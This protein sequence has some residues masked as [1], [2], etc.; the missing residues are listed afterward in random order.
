[1]TGYPS[2]DKPWLKYYSEEALEKELPQCTVYELLWQ[3]NK[4]YFD[5]IALSYLGTEISFKDLFANIEKTAK[6]FAALGVKEGDIVVMVT[7]TTPET[8]YALY[9]LNRLGAIPNM[10]D[11]RTSADGMKE[12]I[13]EVKAK[14]VLILDVVYDKAIQIIEDTSVE[15]VIVT[16]PANSLSIIKKKLYNLFHRTSNSALIAAD[17]F[18]QWDIFIEQGQTSK[19]NSVPYA[20]N[21][22]CLM[23]HT[24]GTTG[25]PKCVMLSNENVNALV[26][27]SIDTEI[28]MQ[29]NHTWLDIMPPFIAYGFGMGLHLPLVIGMKTFLIPQFDP[30]KF[31]E[32]LIKYKPVH[33][34]GVPS[35]W[36]TILKS[37]KLK[38]ADLSYMISPTVGGDSMAPNL[39]EAANQFLKSHGCTSKITKGYGM[40]EVCAGVAGTVDKNNEIGSV[41]IPFSKTI[42]SIF[43]P[44]TESELSYNQMG[45]VCITGPNVMLGYYNN[46]EATKDIIKVH[47]DGKSWIH[48]GDIGYM[49][50]NGSLFIVDRIKKMIVRY[51]GFKVYPAV[52]D[53]AVMKHNAV[54]E[55]CTVGIRDY[56]HT[57]G[58]LPFVYAVLQEQNKM[59]KE[60]IKKQLIELCKNELPEYA[61]P[62]DITF[63]AKMPLTLIGKVDY[64]KLEKDAEETIS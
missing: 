30:F 43:E 18:I 44:D 34:V 56:S 46:E 19:V 25:I 13:K 63:L 51:D 1:M 20:K 10:V 29:R 37:K 35:Y 58:K 23:V 54:I 38:N 59:H 12:Y 62:V 53:Q 8:V 27:Q 36:G 33:M 28:D 47:K 6:A 3:S 17:I 60:E 9:A 2:I 5:N 40:T 24:G 64:R 50:E 42:I 31:D 15:H 26:I 14:Y 57:Q 41:G 16:S 52:V 21:R 55:S 39:E 49:N 32:L 61:Q 11:P 45:E 7:V 4:K 48:S 22:C